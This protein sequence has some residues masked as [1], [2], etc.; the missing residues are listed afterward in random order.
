MYDDFIGLQSDSLTVIL[1]DIIS[2]AIVI[3]ACLDRFIFAPE[4][5][6]SSVCF[7]RKFVGSRYNLFN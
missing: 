5:A 1:F 3:V 7:L 2:G 6:T 4:S